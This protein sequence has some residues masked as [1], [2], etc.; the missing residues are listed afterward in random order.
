MFSVMPSQVVQTINEWYP[1]AKK[2]HGSSNLTAGDSSKL[3]GILN[4]IRNVPPELWLE[5]FIE[6]SAAMKLIQLDTKIAANL[7]RNFR[8]LIHPG[9]AARLKQIC[10]RATAY[11][12]TGALEHIIRDLS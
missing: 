7:A 12:A 5:Q 1:H 3:L 11:S 4:L 6:V 9:R 10:D 8:N 2:G